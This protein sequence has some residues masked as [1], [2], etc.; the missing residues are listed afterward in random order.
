MVPASRGVCA[1]VPTARSR[2]TKRRTT[3]RGRATGSACGDG[4]RGALGV[5]RRAVAAYVCP[6]CTLVG[7]YAEWVMITNN[8]KRIDGDT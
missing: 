1:S 7:F 6:E 2:W 3:R 8:A 5:G 4:L